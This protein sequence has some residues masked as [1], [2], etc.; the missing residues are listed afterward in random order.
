MTMTG[1]AGAAPMHAASA[2]LSTLGGSVDTTVAASGV[3][4]VVVGENWSGMGRITAAASVT[5]LNTDQTAYGQL[6]LLK[7]QLLAAA[8]ELHTMTPPRMVTHVQA[9]AN[10]GEYLVDNAINP[11]VWGALTP[12]LIELDTEYFGFMWP[13]NA[14][15]GLSYGAGLDAIGAGLAALSALPSLAG[16]SVA[17]PAMAAGDVAANAGI[18]MAS[19]AMSTTEQAATAAISPATTAA[20]QSA[21]SG[22]LGQAPLSA[23]ATT[24][25][26]PTVSP[27]ANVQPHTP[28]M[29]SM[30]QAQASAMSMFL[31]PS[32]AAVNP[33]TP[34]P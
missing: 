26:T 15:A 21:G 18:T 22:L 17:A 27:M 33:P 31:P 11:W 19:A 8:G 7:A 6:S 5:T 25:S 14:S 32:T 2:A 34:A 4:D 3:N 16:G 20:S 1:G 30:G 29:P 24:S 23:P 28:A 10:R 12:R 13:N 9:N